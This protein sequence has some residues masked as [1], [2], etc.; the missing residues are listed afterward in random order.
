MTVGYSAVPVRSSTH[1]KSGLGNIQHER[2]QK[3]TT[4]GQ[5]TKLKT[6]HLWEVSKVNGQQGQPGHQQQSAASSV[7]VLYCE[8]VRIHLR[9]QR[10]N[11]LVSG[12]RL[13]RAL[14]L[15]YPLVSGTAIVIQPWIS[16][17]GCSAQDTTLR[18]PY[19]KCIQSR[20]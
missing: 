10:R 6:S 20:T 2:Q 18:H 16:L 7:P 8:D 5:V 11:P 14:L 4:T 3:A 17:L 12:L 9:V 19:V 13:I 1:V 15:I